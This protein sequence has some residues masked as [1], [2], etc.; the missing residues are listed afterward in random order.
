MNPTLDQ[1][2][3]YLKNVGPK[4]AIMLARMGITTIRELLG[5]FPREYEDRRYVTKIG[6]VSS[7]QKVVVLGK[8]EAA[9]AVSAS[10]NLTIFKVAVSDGTGL[11]YALFYRK[12]SPYHRHDVFGALRQAFMQG[13]L[14]YMFGQCD[15]N[16][17]EK[18]MKV[19][20]YEQAQGENES[21]LKH[22]KRIVPLYPLTAGISQKWLRELVRVNLENLV[23]LWLDI[24][25]DTLE[26]KESLMPAQKAVRE[27][28]FPSDFSVA[29]TARKRLAYDEFLLL[30]T[31]LTMARRRSKVKTKAF[32]YD[33]QRTLLTPFKEKLKF[34]FT[35]AQ[36]KVI[37][38]IFADMQKAQPMNRLLLG[39][40]GSGKTVVA[41]SAILL[42]VENGY[43]CV[44]LAPTEILAEQHYITICRML[45]GLGVRISLVTGKLSAKKNEKNRLLDEIGAGNVDLVVGTHAVLEKGISFKKLSLVV[46]DEQHRFGVLQRAT[47]QTKTL[48][49]DVLLMTATPI[50]RTLA[51][52]LYGD[53]DISVI[54]QLPPGR[55][56]IV[57]QHLVA[58]L[59]YDRVKREIRQGHQAYIV[60]PLVEESDK[61]ELKAAVQEAKT[62]SCSVFREF[63][64]GLLHGQM[65]ADEKQRVMVAFREGTLDILIATTVIE[66]GIDV[67]NATLMV[68]E[69]ADRF[70]LATLHQLRGRVGRGADR[71]YCIL[72]GNPRTDEARKRIE[73]MTTITN[74]FKIAEEDLSLRGPG[75]FFGTA[76]HGMP[77]LKAGNLITDTALIEDSRALAA[78]IVASDPGLKA[79][80]HQPLKQ[81]VFRVYGNRLCL[82]KIG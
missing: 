57:T 8:V 27:I 38:E 60:Y 46:I 63:R 42:A 5:Y 45:E 56:P 48:H 53:M 76:Q 18:Q 24:L 64:V 30:E 19:E 13:N 58:A 69:H 25:P 23:P 82:L 74:G 73:V 52:T 9:E 22:F 7:G 61:V 4:R 41:L 54:D 80:A 66:V 59:A 37:N 55:Q 77:V 40:V 34:V 70:G 11:L 81:E 78:S 26:H 12:T 32:S 51:L 17:G 29:A 14:V 36:K 15:I 6:S 72:L 65:K 43:Q 62:L 49:P 79:E 68:I 50:P 28:H 71:S 75:E 67:P 44:L 35:P 39:D 10:R 2:V 20:E 3:Q 16:F 31:A 21:D 33:I 1:S 47:L